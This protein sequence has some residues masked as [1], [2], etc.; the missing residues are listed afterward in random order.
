[1]GQ[2]VAPALGAGASD[3]GELVEVGLAVAVEM[4]GAGEGSMLVG[5][6]VAD[7]VV[8]ADEAA[9]GADPPH[10]ATATIAAA[11]TAALTDLPRLMVPSLGPPSNL[12]HR[13]TDPLT[14]HWAAAPLE[15]TR[16]VDLLA[17]QSHRG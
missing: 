7:V 12:T 8:D 17:A 16:P 11:P 13:A 2:R 5:T 3:L 10:P 1:M 14:A 6:L 15:R 4:L 9:G